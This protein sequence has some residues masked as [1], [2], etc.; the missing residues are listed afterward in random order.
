MAIAE[1]A[2]IRMRERRFYLITALVFPVIVLIG[3]GR[4][5]YLKPFFDAPPLSSYLVEIHA[6]I[7][8][9]WVLLFIAQ[10]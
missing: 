4:T 10:V 2:L 6:A 7:M 1:S 3:F 9:A 5:F 8:T